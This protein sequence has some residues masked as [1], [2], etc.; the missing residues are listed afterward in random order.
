MQSTIDP[1]VGPEVESA[2]LP[3][4]RVLLPFTVLYIAGMWLARPHTENW[5]HHPVLVLSLSAL[6]ILLALNAY[7]TG[8]RR[9]VLISSILYYSSFLLGYSCDISGISAFTA[10]VSG[11]GSVRKITLWR[12]ATVA[13][14]LR[15]ADWNEN[16][17]RSLLGATLKLNRGAAIST[18]VSVFLEG[19]R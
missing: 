2:R 5:L 11:S 15:P 18:A 10:E 1:A 19:R 12:G 9:L 14:E 17:L 7:E 16:E 8:S 13:T 4:N 6:A 3:S